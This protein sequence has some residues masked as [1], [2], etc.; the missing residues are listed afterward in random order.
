M[1]GGGRTAS[2]AHTRHPTL[3]PLPPLI[4]PA[5]GYAPPAFHPSRAARRVDREN[6]IA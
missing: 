2:P 3:Q 6:Q 1:I 4:A 5:R